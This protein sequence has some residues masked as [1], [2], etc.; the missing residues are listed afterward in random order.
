MF[1]LQ[2]AAPTRSQPRVCISLLQPSQRA[3]GTVDVTISASRAATAGLPGTTAQRWL[4]PRPS[5]SWAQ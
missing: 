1:G 4:Q 2:S 5:N 3:S